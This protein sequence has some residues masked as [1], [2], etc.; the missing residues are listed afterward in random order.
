MAH[1]WRTIGAEISAKGL[2][3]GCRAPFH[4]ISKEIRCLEMAQRRGTPRHCSGP[5]P[6]MAQEW[7]GNGANPD[8]RPG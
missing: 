1:N 4:R 8:R 3:A 6:E 7:R 2:A 5:E